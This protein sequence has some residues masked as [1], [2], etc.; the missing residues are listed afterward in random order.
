MLDEENEGP[1]PIIQPLIIEEND[2]FN[3]LL[4]RSVATYYGFQIETIA[5]IKHN[6]TLEKD[7]KEDVDDFKDTNEKDDID[8]N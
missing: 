4:A 7:K 5:P 1:I 8:K 3:R 2:P 6:K